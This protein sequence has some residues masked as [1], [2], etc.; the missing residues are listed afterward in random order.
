[1]QKLNKKYIVWQEVFDDGVEITKGTIVNVWKPG[2]KLELERV[3]S[4]GHMAVVSSCWYLNYLKYGLDWPKHYKCDP[5]SFTTN[6]E[7]RKLV[8]GGSA[9]MWGEY[10]DATNVIQYSFG[11]SFAVAERLWSSE[12]VTDV[13][14]ALPRIWE[15]QCRYIS[16]GLPAE[17]VT[18]STYCRK[19]W[20]HQYS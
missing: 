19:E 5:H 17:P 15:H 18:R 10:V 7:K 14:E 3:T 1:M 2:W 6:E 8:I 16:R 20:N 4:A 9:A 11:R 12:D 13:K